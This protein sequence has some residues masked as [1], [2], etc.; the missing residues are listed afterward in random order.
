MVK[1][2]SVSGVLCDTKVP[3][4]LKGKFYRTTVRSTMLYMRDCWA[5]KNQHKH[6]ISVAE[7]MMLCWM[8]GKAEIDLK[9]TTLE[10]ES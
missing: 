5:V 10:R 3:L 2:R 9:M 6:K 8:H 7:I 1:W 4:K